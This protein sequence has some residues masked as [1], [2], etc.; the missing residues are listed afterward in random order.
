[1]NESEQLD[2]VSEME[3]MVLKENAAKQAGRIIKDEQDE[4]V[5]VEFESYAKYF[6]FAGGWPVIVIFTFLMVGFILCQLA[7]N[8]YTQKWAYG[9][10]EDQ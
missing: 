5:K 4:I 1:M 7:A 8:F 2:K 10:P 3:D 9:S 6:R